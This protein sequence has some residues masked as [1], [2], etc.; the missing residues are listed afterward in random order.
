MTA[1][2]A[3][4]MSQDDL[5]RVVGMKQQGID[6]IEKGDVERPRKMRELARELKKSEEFLLYGTEPAERRT[7][8][9]DQVFSPDPPAD[10][11]ITEID[12]PFPDALP[13]MLGRMGAGSTGA[14]ITIDVGEMQSRE[15]V[16]EW[17]RI[18]PA[19]LRGLARSDVSRTIGF[20]MDGADSMEPTIL[21]TDIVFIDTGRQKIEP[22]GIWA[23]DYG[24][25]RIVKRVSIRKKN[26]E[27]YYV[28]KSDNPTYPEEEYHEDEVTIFG[29]YI[30][31]F[32]VF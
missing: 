6:S 10:K 28:I 14:V 22:D 32:S 7:V 27:T 5:A 1:R 30:G 8:P 16:G 20:S 21:R 12:K 31:R 2:K 24:F 4:G 29:R 18:P 26:D 25:G 9:M 19:V 15:E 3:L 17:W 11:I 13:Q 23:L